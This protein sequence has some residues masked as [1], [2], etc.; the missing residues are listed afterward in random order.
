MPSVSPIKKSPV[1]QYLLD[2]KYFVKHEKDKIGRNNYYYFFG[3]NNDYLG[4]M[5]IHPKGMHELEVHKLMF[6]EKLKP[7]FREYTRIK[8]KMG[9]FWSKDSIEKDEYLPTGYTTTRIT[10][11]LENKTQTMQVIERVLE[12]EPKLIQGVKEKYGTNAY[13]LENQVF[14]YKI[15]SVTEETKP[16]KWGKYSKYNIFV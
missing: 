14:K 7:I 10:I 9:S 12:Q 13:E 11:D 2:N 8:A 15:K 3:A 5:T 1:T 6:K 16:Y 4:E